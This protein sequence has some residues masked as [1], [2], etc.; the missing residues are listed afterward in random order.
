MAN[1]IEKRIEVV[2]ITHQGKKTVWDVVDQHGKERRAYLR[3][4]T[5]YY[6]MPKFEAGLLKA[7]K[8]ERQ[9]LE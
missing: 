9:S 5:F 8:F 7:D 1:S 2:T 3:D 4:S 6:D